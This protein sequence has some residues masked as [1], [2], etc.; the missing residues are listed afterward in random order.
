MGVYESKDLA[1]RMA[2]EQLMEDTKAV[3]RR[4]I[5]ECQRTVDRYKNER[6]Q[7][8]AQDLR[9]RANLLEAEADL[10]RVP[11]V[12]ETPEVSEHHPDSYGT[13][14]YHITIMTK[15][16]HTVRI[17]PYNVT[18]VESVVNAQMEASDDPDAG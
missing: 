15:H 8:E 6:V 16:Y 12:E 18:T 11:P 2:Q 3:W 1:I 14:R 13:K 9:R 7:T 10:K 4:Q 5:E 17:E